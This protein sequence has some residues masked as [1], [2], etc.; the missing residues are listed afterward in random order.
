MT[1]YPRLR[2]YLL[3]WRQTLSPIT[4]MG[5]CGLF[6]F[7]AYFFFTSL[8]QIPLQQLDTLATRAFFELPAFLLA[9]WVAV[10]GYTGLYFGLIAVKFGD[11]LLE[12]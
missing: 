2:C 11:S 9:L 4:R 6:S 10:L 8:G 1:V 7:L 12:T 3:N 5:F